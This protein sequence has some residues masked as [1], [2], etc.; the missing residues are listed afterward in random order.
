MHI[1]IDSREKAKAIKKIIAE[2]DKQGVEHFTSKCYV[3][4]YVSLDNSRLAIDRK[5]NLSELYGNLCQAHKRFAAELIRAKEAG[6]ALIILIEHGGKINSLEDVKGWVNPRLKFSPY[7]W[8]G[9]RM[10]KTM[11]TVQVKYGVT[12]EFCSKAK[13][14]N[15]II[16]ILNGG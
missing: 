12:F 3:G 10:Y 6:I 11:L 4:D 15:K 9:M 7:A 8:D 13:T 14:G 1:C 2:F 5:Q 16:E